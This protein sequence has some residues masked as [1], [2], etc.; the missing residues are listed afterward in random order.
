[1]STRYQDN[2]GDGDR[3]FIDNTATIGVRVVTPTYKWARIVGE[4]TFATR[5]NDTG[6]RFFSIGSDNGLRGFLINE[7]SGAR[8]GD[9]LFR[10]QVEMRTVPRPL[11]V[12]RLGGVLFYE[13]GGVGDTLAGNNKIQLHHDVGVGFRMLIPQTARDLFRFDFAIPLDGNAAGSLRFI[14]GFESAF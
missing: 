11:W 14:A 10:T 5:W 8:T 9:R 7:F 3:E 12:L 6:N 1:M 2:D 13:V 4:S